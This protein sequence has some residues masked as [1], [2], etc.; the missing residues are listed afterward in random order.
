MALCEALCV[1]H[2]SIH[3]DHFDGNVDLSAVDA[4]LLNDALQLPM[5]KVE[6]MAHLANVLHG[7]AHRASP[8]EE[9][10]H[11]GLRHTF[12][13]HRRKCPTVARH[14]VVEREAFQNLLHTRQ[15]PADNL[16]QH[17]DIAFSAVQRNSGS[18][19]I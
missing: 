2:P 11:A 7:D 19:I 3:A 15:V 1:K 12:Y 5:L 9:R 8:T 18:G 13:A 17:V 16:R 6:L 4:F 10:R 14:R